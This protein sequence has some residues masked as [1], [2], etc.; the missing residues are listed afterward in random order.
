MGVVVNEF[1]INNLRFA[2]DIAVTVDKTAQECTIMGMKINSDKTEGQ[3]SSSSSSSLSS[4]PATECRCDIWLGINM[5]V[6]QKVRERRL[7]YCG[8]VCGMHPGRL[9]YICF[10]GRVEGEWTRGRRV[11]TIPRIACISLSRKLPAGRP[12]RDAVERINGELIELDRDAAAG[13]MST[14]NMR[15]VLIPSIDEVRLRPRFSG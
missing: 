6:I 15:Y 5:D 9:P 10:H 2:D 13:E 12:R 14:W 1:K 8:R 11:F 4:V 7:R 3:V